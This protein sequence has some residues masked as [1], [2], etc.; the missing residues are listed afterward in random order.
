MDT[1]EENFSN[2]NSMGSI[3]SL[4]ENEAKTEPYICDFE[5]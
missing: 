5:R 2:D 3:K 1:K 4:T